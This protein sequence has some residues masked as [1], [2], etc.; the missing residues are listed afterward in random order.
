VVSISANPGMIRRLAENAKHSN[1]NQVKPVYV[2]VGGHEAMIDLNIPKDEVGIV[3]V[4]ESE[5][6]KLPMRPLKSILAGRSSRR[7]ERIASETYHFHD[8]FR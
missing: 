1:M 5:T 7:G 6:G 8:H 4:V 3:N 2:A